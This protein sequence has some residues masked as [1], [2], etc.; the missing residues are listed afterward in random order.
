[1]MLQFSS[2]NPSF[3]YATIMSPVPTFRNSVTAVDHAWNTIRQLKWPK[4]WNG[5]TKATG[6]VATIHL[7]RA[8]TAKPLDA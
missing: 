3:C 1:M 2:D 7:A 8:T 4:M 6:V 5:I